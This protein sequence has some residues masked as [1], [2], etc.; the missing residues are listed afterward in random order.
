[1]TAHENAVQRISIVGT[2]Y[3]GL[4]TAVCFA[5]RGYDVIASTRSEDK[6]RIINSKRAPFHE[7]GLDEAVRAGIESGHLRAEI[8]RSEA[9]RQTE[10]TF[11]TVGTPE[12]ADGTVDLRYV[13]SASE[14]IG[15]A[16]KRKRAYHLVV[17]KSTVPPGTTRGSIKAALEEASGLVAGRDFGLCM[18]PEFLRQGS[19]LRDTLYTDRVVIGE[20]DERSG[21][22]LEDLLEGFY[23]PGV[24]IL[25]M[26][27]E[28]A[29]MV[30][31]ASNTYL[32]MKISYA[33]EMANICERVPGVDVS[34]VMAGVGLDERINPKFLNAGAGFGGSCLPKD[35]RALCK[36]AEE[37]GYS[38]PLLRATLV[39][40]QAQAFHV[41]QLALATLGEPRDKKV[42]LLG[43]AFKPDTD[44]L[45]QA[46]SLTVARTLMNAGAHV[47]AFDPVV[48]R[49][50]QPGFERLDYPPSIS[51][52]LAGAH[53]C[54]VLTEWEPFKR[55]TPDDFIQS[56]ATPAVVDARRIFDPHE[57]G[58]RLTFLAVGLGR[59]LDVACTFVSD[60]DE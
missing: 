34:K 38:A 9:V 3:V 52:C 16:T 37:Q 50:S 22:Q 42:A 20:Y 8:N 21:Q 30:K 14:D 25:R 47:S 5:S 51:E 33:N 53:C 60:D 40:N 56:M 55:L 7:P 1:M 59:D 46:P 24:P 41:A 10:V 27:L 17:V 23:G 4:S 44:D 35:T 2:G 58:S 13:I 12:N 57:F 11:I 28:S 31:Y 39:I 29:E 43:L 15:R 48:K 32:A 45:R 36:F 6:V 26:S 19:A 54:I 18:N 49:V